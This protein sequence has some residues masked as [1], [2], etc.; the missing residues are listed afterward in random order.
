MLQEFPISPRIFSESNFFC[1]LGSIK[2]FKAHEIN[3]SPRSLKTRKNKYSNFFLSFNENKLPLI[4][5]KVFFVCESTLY[6][7]SH[8]LAHKIIK[9][10]DDNE[11]LDQRTTK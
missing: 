1:N 10:I 11:L 8:F 7:N 9:N 6:D 4:C 5:H 2:L 3:F